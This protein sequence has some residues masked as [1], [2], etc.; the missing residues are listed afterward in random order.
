MIVREGIILNNVQAFDHS[1]EG[2]G[3]IN[4]DG[5]RIFVDNLLPG[6]YADILIKKSNSKFAF[7]K[8]VKRHNDSPQ[9]ID[10]NNEQL[11]A[12]GAVSLSNISYENQLSFKQKV[13]ESLF[14]RNLNIDIVKDILPS[15]EKWRYRNK[16]TVFIKKAKNGYKTGLFEKNTHNLIEQKNYLLAST[17]VEKILLFVNEYFKNNNP[18]D[19]KSFPESLTIRESNL[20]NN[21][22]LIF[23][24]KDQFSLNKLFIKELKHSFPNIKN[25]IA[26]NKGRFIKKYLDQETFIIDKI[27]SFNFVINYNSFFQVNSYQTH[28]LYNLLID[29]LNIKR[30]DVV[31]DAYSGIGTISLF[32]AQKAKKVIGLEIISDAVKNAKENAILNNVNNLDF[33]AGDVINSINKVKD[34]IDI[35]VVDPP[36]SGLDKKFLNKIMDLNCDQIGY[37]SCNPNTLCRDSKILVENGYELVFIQPCDMFCQTHHV[38]TVAIFKKLKKPVL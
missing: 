22:L 37:I 6:E 32:L 7:A 16:I 36:R 14:K 8:V 1:F 11:M 38:E 17:E 13:V 35:V 9:R 20:N 29:N 28:N 2:L 25:I 4:I 5:Y 19:S 34:K 31:L 27:G 33:F 24:G 3:V 26:L 18:F 21:K 23:D 10:I 30:T 12:S 15:R